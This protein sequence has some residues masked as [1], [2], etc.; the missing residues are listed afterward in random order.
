MVSR[1]QQDW[2]FKLPLF[3]LAYRS[4]VYETTGYTPSLML[5]G[6]ELRLPC[7]LFVGHL[8][9]TLSS[10]EEEY[11]RDL[12][13]CFEHVHNFDRERISLATERMKTRYNIKAMTHEFQ[14]GEKV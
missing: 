6:R 11:L 3:L 9:D 2:D 5:F 4:A 1:N 13:V 7:D 12:L 14:E 8:P 10:P